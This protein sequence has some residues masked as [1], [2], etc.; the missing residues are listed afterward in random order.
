[1]D[2]CD[3]VTEKSQNGGCYEHQNKKIKLAEDSEGNDEGDLISKVLP[4][5]DEDSENNSVVSELTANLQNQATNVNIKHRVID[6]FFPSPFAKMRAKPKLFNHN[7]FSSKVYP[8]IPY[9]QTILPS[10]E[11]KIAYII[12]TLYELKDFINNRDLKGA[13]NVI[14]ELCLDNCLLKT[15]ALS[16]PRMG[17]SYIT[18][19]ILSIIRSTVNFSTDISSHERTF[20]N[21]ST[22]LIIN[23][24]GESKYSY[25]NI[26][27]II[28]QLMIHIFCLS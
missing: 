1:M 9:S 20:V 7:S 25:S 27:L 22:V 2:I 3:S 17:R 26:H 19:L 14:N 13:E 5:N 23:F 12:K 8:S 11:I 15:P 16:T 28:I 18:E 4:S 10:D 21:G 6:T 24:V